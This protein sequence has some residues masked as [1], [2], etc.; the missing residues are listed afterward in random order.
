MTYRTIISVIFIY[1]SFV[2]SFI[3]N[4]TTATYFSVVGW[5]LLLLCGVFIHYSQTNTKRSNKLF[6]CVIIWPV[7]MT[8]LSF[9]YDT[10]IC[11]NYGI[12]TI[13]NPIFFPYDKTVIIAW[14]LYISCCLMI[15][16]IL[17]KKK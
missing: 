15:D 7:L 8:P 5:L 11:Q 3:F 9:L 2:Y 4:T 16:W 6:W 10:I 12:L 1:L 14:L 13:F 17:I